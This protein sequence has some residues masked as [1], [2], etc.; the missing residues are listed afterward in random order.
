MRASLIIPIIFIFQMFTKC[1]SWERQCA[2]KNVFRIHSLIG[3][4]DSCKG[5][6]IPKD[7]ANSFEILQFWI[8]PFP[9]RLWVLKRLDDCFIVGKY[10]NTELE[11][12]RDISME[13]NM[14]LLTI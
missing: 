10:T 4:R 2:F 9:V 8:L 12:C 6:C 7:P 11:S 13:I 5:L 14:I 3:L 1:L